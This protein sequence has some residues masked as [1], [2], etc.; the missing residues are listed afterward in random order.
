MFSGLKLVFTGGK[1]PL[2]PLCF[3]FA[4]VLLALTAILFFFVLR[5][6]TW[7]FAGISSRRAKVFATQVQRH[8]GA[9]YTPPVV[10]AMFRKRG[11]AAASGSLPEDVTHIVVDNANSR[12]GIQELLG[13][14]EL[15]DSVKVRIRSP[16]LGQKLAGLSVFLL[17]SLWN[18][19]WGRGC[20]L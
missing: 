8:G 18:A 7:S 10:P 16:C 14:S 15:P 20:R 17:R 19:N 12:A 4:S 6:G 13:V 5:S 11:A 1:R 2:T 9:V 3:L